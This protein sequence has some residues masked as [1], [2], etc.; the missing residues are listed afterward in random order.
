MLQVVE[1][2]PHHREPDGDRE[3]CE[4]EEL[5]RRIHSVALEVLIVA[6]FKILLEVSIRPEAQRVKLICGPVQLDRSPKWG[7]VWLSLAPSSPFAPGGMDFP[8]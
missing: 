2:L 5:Y 1:P 6:V 8:V 7:L 4:D 3:D